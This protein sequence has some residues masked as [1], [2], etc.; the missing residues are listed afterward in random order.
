MG[1]KLP[2]WRGAANAKAHSREPAQGVAV[3]TASQ[4]RKEIESASVK[5]RRAK[6]QSLPCSN[7]A[8]LSPARAGLRRTEAQMACLP[9][10]C[11]RNEFL[12]PDVSI[13]SEIGRLFIR[14][15][16]HAALPLYPKLSVI[17]YVKITFFS[18]TL[19]KSRERNRA[20]KQRR[21]SEVL[22]VFLLKFHRKLYS[23][24][25]SC[26]RA[27][28]ALLK[29]CEFRKEKEL[30]CT[31]NSAAFSEELRQAS[32]PCPEIRV[33]RIPGSR[34]WAIDPRFAAARRSL[35]RPRNGFYALANEAVARLFTG[36][37]LLE[38][39][40][41]MAPNHTP[42]ALCCCDCCRYSTARVC[43]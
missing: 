22:C 34:C 30:F 25:H 18:R 29:E 37:A 3:K 26:V 4:A 2:L 27:L 12:H 14:S 6:L 40:R 9:S 41:Q 19:A 15:S 35:T 17:Q 7:A 43:L 31:K 5:A 11:N 23:Y 32:L 28:S 16:A 38:G 20:C 13:Q 10:A 39:S 1:S 33:S 21:S 8:P 36:A 42:S 24:C